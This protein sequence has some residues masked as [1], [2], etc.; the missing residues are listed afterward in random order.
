MSILLENDQNPQLTV[1]RDR[2]DFILGGSADALSAHA[3]VSTYLVNTA[4]VDAMTLANP[5]AGADDGKVFTIVSLTAQ[6]HTLTCSAGSL[7]AGATGNTVGTFAAHPGAS[8]RLMAY[9]GKWYVLA[10]TAIAFT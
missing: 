8:I 7:N 3:A 6:A 9:Q 1:F 2:T 5:T 4:G 10:S